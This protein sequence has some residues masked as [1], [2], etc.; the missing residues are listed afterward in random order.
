LQYGTPER[1]NTLAH[2]LRC[3]SCIRSG[4]NFM[5]SPYIGDSLLCS[6]KPS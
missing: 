5:V 2:I 3:P 1:V 4:V 6:E